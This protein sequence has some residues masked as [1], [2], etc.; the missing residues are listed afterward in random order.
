LIHSAISYQ[1]ADGIPH[2]MSDRSLFA[3]FWTG[4]GIMFLAFLL[5]V[6]FART[7]ARDYANAA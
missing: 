7:H 1:G 4:A 6:Y 2:F 3:T 5:A